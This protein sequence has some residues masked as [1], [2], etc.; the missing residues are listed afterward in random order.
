MNLTLSWVAALTW[1]NVLLEG[2][3]LVAMGAVT[4]SLLAYKPWGLDSGT[5]T[6]ISTMGLVGMGLGGLASGTATDRFG[7][8]RVLVIAVAVF[9]LFTL[10]CGIAPSPELFG[11][12]RFFAGLGLGG[13]LPT[14]LAIVSE[15]AH[16]RRR[17][18]ATTFVFTAY[19]VGGV[20]AAGLALVLLDSPGWRSLFIIGA[21]PGLVLVPLFMR[22]LPESPRYLVARG[23]IAE[24]EEIAARHG[25]ELLGETPESS[26]GLSA[27]R[28]VRQLFTR[29]L[30]RNSLTIWMG[31]FMGLLLVYGLNTWLPVLMRKA[32]Y[33]L[34]AAITFLLVLNAG[35]ILGLL[36]SGKIADKIGPRTAAIGWFT[37]AGVLIALL[38]RDIGGAIYVVVFF[39]GAFVF[40]SQAL[41]YVFTSTYY[42]DHV[43]ATALGW[44]AGIGRAGAICGPVLGGALIG[45][46]LAVPWGFFAFGAVG[47][48]GAIAMLCSRSGAP[49]DS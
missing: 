22:Y 40:G 21:V 34:G 23:R 29:R 35:A 13:A 36:A 47:L 44:S 30:V 37:G 28:L 43:R 11:V 7:R 39:A 15:F 26:D 33:D 25:L 12:F 5:L 10:L 18:S 4:P 6:L 31:S 14:S 32:G 45:A 42:S 1:L 3:D 24:A 19:Q 49:A 41:I 27:L 46:N 16:Q 8:R 38:S 17:G 9:S 48:L 20:A 2:Y